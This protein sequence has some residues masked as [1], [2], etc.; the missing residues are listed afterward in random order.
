MD[1]AD[2]VRLL[3]PAVPTATPEATW[4]D[5]GAGSGAFTLALADL[6]GPGASI[7]AVDRDERALRENAKHIT[8]SFPGTTFGTL[9]AD[10]ATLDVDALPPLDGLVAANSLHF[11]PRPVQVAVVASLAA[12]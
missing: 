10:F 2:H 12:R 11:V 4:A 7:I 6:L 1:H 5:F 8:S 9:V 3:E